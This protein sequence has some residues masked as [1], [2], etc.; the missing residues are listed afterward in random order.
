M[1]RCGRRHGPQS[2]PDANKTQWIWEPLSLKAIEDLRSLGN[3]FFDEHSYDD[4]NT[5]SVDTLILVTPAG[6]I[7][8]RDLEGGTIVRTSGSFDAGR[9]RE[10]PVIDPASRLLGLELG[11]S[12]PGLATGNEW[13]E[14]CLP[15]GLD[16][17]DDPPLDA[18]EC[19]AFGPCAS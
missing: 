7:V 6:G 18:P 11:R 8:Y 10:F 2:W 19:A 16:P 12:L 5:G 17:T 3:V 14:V 1:P 15:T 9:T 13:A 4:G